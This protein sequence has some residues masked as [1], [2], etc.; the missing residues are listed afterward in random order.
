MPLRCCLFFNLSVVLLC[1]LTFVLSDKDTAG[2]LTTPGRSPLEGSD[3][4][5]PLSFNDGACNK[6][7]VE[8]DPQD[9]ARYFQ[10]DAFGNKIPDNRTRIP[11]SQCYVLCG[12]GYDRYSNTDILKRVALWLVPVFVLVGNFQFPPLGPLNS[13]FIAAHLFGDPIHTMYSLL[14]KIEV[15]R[16]I[17]ELWVNSSPPIMEGELYGDENERNRALRDIAAVNVLFDEWNYSAIRVYPQLRWLFDRLEGERRKNFI[18]ACREAAHKLSDSRVNDS[19][20]TWLAVGGYVVGVASAFLKTLETGASNRTA[21]TIAFA[22][23]YSWLIPAVVMSASVGGFASTR[24]GRRVIREMKDELEDDW[25]I[26]DP[27]DVFYLSIARLPLPNRLRL[28]KVTTLEESFRFFGSYS[29]R[30]DTSLKFPGPSRLE[31]GP[32]HSWIRSNCSLLLLSCIP[33]ITATLSALCLS[34]MHPPVGLGCRS[35]TQIIFCIT[36][37]LSALFTKLAGGLFSGKYYFRLIIAKDLLLAVMQIGFILAAFVGFYN[38]CFCWSNYLSRVNPAFIEV[39]QPKALA[40]MVR[41]K[42]PVIVIAGLSVQGLV[43]LMMYLRS[44]E[45]LKIFERSEAEQAQIFGEL[46]WHEKKITR[47]CSVASSEC[48]DN[49]GSRKESVGGAGNGKLFL[50]P[51]LMKLGALAQ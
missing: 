8:L 33:I 49:R 30:H 35:L 32:T 13:F 11:L 24:T 27:A 44:G 2:N 26:P 1:C 51:V 48:I 40:D 14:V 41:I 19:L 50:A 18:A 9:P 29:F 4:K 28:K 20:R 43:L 36:W 42:W 17:H 45:G 12:L 37:L 25:M 34:W 16:R 47:K 3:H 21:H 6:T 46:M 31:T 10:K 7:I 15:S 5:T 39:V 22:V 23:L 38:S